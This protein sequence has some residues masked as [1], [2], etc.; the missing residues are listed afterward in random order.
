M[1]GS[2]LQITIWLIRRLDTVDDMG[3]KQ[4]VRNERALH[5]YNRVQHKLTGAPM[6]YYTILVI[7][8][9]ESGRD[10]NPEVALSIQAQVERL[11]QDS[12]SLE[13]LCQCFSGW[14]V[15][16]YLLVRSCS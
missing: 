6:F 15:L 16:V 4:E 2:C 11:I 10:F 3:A 1:V 8:D 14:C 12:T 5:V 7:L 9:H 13:K